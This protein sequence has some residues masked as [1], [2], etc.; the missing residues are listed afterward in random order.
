M[1]IPKRYEFMQLIED[2]AIGFIPGHLL[3]YDY[4]HITIRYVILL[5]YQ[6]NKVSNKGKYGQPDNPESVN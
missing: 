5:T 1:A 2:H 4:Y 3:G 6:I